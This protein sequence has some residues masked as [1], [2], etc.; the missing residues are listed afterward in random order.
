VLAAKNSFSFNYRRYAASLN[1]HLIKYLDCIRIWKKVPQGENI[2]DYLTSTL[3]AMFVEGATLV[4]Q[5]FYDMGLTRKEIALF[6]RNVS[7]KN[8]LKSTSSNLFS[9]LSYAFV[10]CWEFTALRGLSHARASARWG[11]GR[12]ST[13]PI[14]RAGLRMIC[15]NLL[16]F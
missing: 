8:S 12:T 15:F 5:R 9:T 4:D 11:T 1:L 14:E 10:L 13:C 7:N 2:L 16:C 3:T 6:M